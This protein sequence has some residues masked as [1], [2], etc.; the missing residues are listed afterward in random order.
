MTRGLRNL[1][2][3]RPGSLSPSLPREFSRS[4]WMEVEVA[5]DVAVK[6]QA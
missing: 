6:R 4:P 1:F 5:D 2:P 3:F